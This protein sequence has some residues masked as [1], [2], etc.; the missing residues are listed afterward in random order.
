MGRMTEY[1]PPKLTGRLAPL[2]TL[3]QP[4]NHRRAWEKSRQLGIPLTKYIDGLI[5]R[6]NGVPSILDDV[7]QGRLPVPDPR[8]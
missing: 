6:D 3:I 7:E 4:E 8:T 2:N 5:A 1:K